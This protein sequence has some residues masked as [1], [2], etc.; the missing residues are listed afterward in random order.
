MHSKILKMSFLGVRQHW[1][2][3]SDDE[4]SSPIVGTYSSIRCKQ[5]SLCLIFSFLRMIIYIPGSPGNKYSTPIDITDDRRK[6]T[7]SSSDIVNDS[8]VSNKPD[9]LEISAQK[10]A[11]RPLHFAFSRCHTVWEMFE[12]I[13][14]YFTDYRGQDLNCDNCRIWLVN[15]ADP[16]ET[17]RRPKSFPLAKAST[18]IIN[19][20][21]NEHGID[22]CASTTINLMPIDL[23][24]VGDQQLA[25][26][27]ADQELSSLCSKE[28]PNHEARCSCTFSF[29]IECKLAHLHL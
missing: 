21:F 28:L 12:S 26:F 5:I 24:M 16:T 2:S 14:K 20:S 25:H 7:T 29:V 11:A 6:R 4:K 22:S 9:F 27:L 19:S 8:I 3:A 13:C 23:K 15:S 17:S 18:G 10:L 1:Y